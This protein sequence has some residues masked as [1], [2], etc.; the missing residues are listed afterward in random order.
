MRFGAS[1]PN[2]DAAVASARTARAAFVSA[3]ISALILRKQLRSPTAVLLLAIANAGL[4]IVYAQ[5]LPVAG[6]AGLNVV[7]LLAIFCASFPA[8]RVSRSPPSAVRSCF[9]L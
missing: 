4:L 1:S 8:W 6:V 2:H 9:T 5:L 3:S 7:V